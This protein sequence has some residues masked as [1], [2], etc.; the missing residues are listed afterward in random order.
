MNKL[1]QG[2]AKFMASVY[3][4][5]LVMLNPLSRIMFGNQPPRPMATP[6]NA[7]KQIMPAMTRTGN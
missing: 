4:S 5:D 2:T 1:A 3:C 7:E 6:K